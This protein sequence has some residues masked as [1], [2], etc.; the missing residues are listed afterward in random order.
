MSGENITFGDV[1]A[2]CPQLCIAS[3]VA[4]WPSYGQRS[5]VASFEERISRLG[6]RGFLQLL[7]QNRL[8]AIKNMLT[9]V[10]IA[11]LCKADE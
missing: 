2:L 1:T 9:T 11:T 6:V 4:A 3:S 7:H 5:G 8:V 10:I